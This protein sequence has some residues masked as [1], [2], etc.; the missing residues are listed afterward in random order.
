LLGRR[1]HGQAQAPI[2]ARSI[3]GG[4]LGSRGMLLFDDATYRGLLV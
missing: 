1:L 2:K 4:L 3:A